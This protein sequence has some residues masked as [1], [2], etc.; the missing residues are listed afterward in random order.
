MYGTKPKYDEAKSKC[1]GQN[2]KV[3]TECNNP[4]ILTNIN[5]LRLKWL[6]ITQN[7]MS[8]LSTLKDKNKL[9]RADIFTIWKCIYLSINYYYFQI[10]LLLF[11]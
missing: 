10:C 4:N 8:I 3:G 2:Q 7:K 9:I 11:L 5:S 1:L 6:I